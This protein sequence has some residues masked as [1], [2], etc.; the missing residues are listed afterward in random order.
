MPI[1]MFTRLNLPRLLDP[2]KVEASLTKD[3]MAEEARCL[4]S[5]TRLPDAVI[6]DPKCL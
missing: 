5:G 2:R 6:R 1:W 3:A 4:A